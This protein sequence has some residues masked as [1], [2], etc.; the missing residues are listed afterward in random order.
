MR[1][2]HGVA[3]SVRVNAVDGNKQIVGTVC[4]NN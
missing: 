1:V 2:R 4:L 3:E